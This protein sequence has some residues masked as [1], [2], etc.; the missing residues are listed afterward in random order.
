[1][2]LHSEKNA[3]DAAINIWR[4]MASEIISIVGE[5]GFN[6]LYARSL[7]IAR[8]EFPWLA[9]AAHAVHADSRFTE[10]KNSFENKTPA[11]ITKAN[12]QL[13]IVFTDIVASVIG[14]QLTMSILRS[15]WGND[16]WNRSQP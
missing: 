8:P 4:L 15:A 14:E 16:V 10:L 11:Q 7:F 9:E 2:A 12:L 6:S 3:A 5:S 1:M 13:L